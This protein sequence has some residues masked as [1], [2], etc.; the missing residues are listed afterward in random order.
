MYFKGGSDTI[1]EEYYSEKKSFFVCLLF[2]KRPV[3]CWQVLGRVEG[4]QSGKGVV[5]A[6]TGEVCVGVAG[7]LVMPDQLCSVACTRDAGYGGG[8]IG[9][10]GKMGTRLLDSQGLL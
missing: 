6:G 5:V 3:A 7:C 10:R 4:P 1:A 2:F 9:R 8:W